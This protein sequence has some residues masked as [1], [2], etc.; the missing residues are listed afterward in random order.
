MPVSRVMLVAFG[1][2][3]L[4][5]PAVVSCLSFLISSLVLLFQARNINF[6][7]LKRRYSLTV[8]Y[9]LTIDG[10]LVISRVDCR[11]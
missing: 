8:L 4:V 7:L 1:M 2:H 9:F 3:R 5:L 10:N 11:S 6:A